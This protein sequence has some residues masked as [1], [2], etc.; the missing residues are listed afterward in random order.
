MR[1]M[2]AT[3]PPVLTSAEQRWLDTFRKM[4]DECRRDNLRAMER[5]AGLFPR[6]TKPEL[7]LVAGRAK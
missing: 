3:T 6:R 7:H 4:D 2:S 1:L 5:M